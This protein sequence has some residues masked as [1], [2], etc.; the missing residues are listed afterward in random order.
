MLKMICG[1]CRGET[2]I[3][4]NTTEPLSSPWRVLRC[5]I[6]CNPQAPSH[7]STMKWLITAAQVLKKGIN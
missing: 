5:C 3:L 7:L 2:E 6:R 4:I 1:N